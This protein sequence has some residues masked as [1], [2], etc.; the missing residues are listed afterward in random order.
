MCRLNGLAGG[1]SWLDDSNGFLCRLVPDGRGAPPADSGP[2]T[3]PNIQENLGGTAPGRTYQDLLTSAYEERLYDY[4]Y[5]SQ[6]AFVA[7]DGRKTTLGAPAVYASLALSTDGQW[8]VVTRVK[9][10][11]SY[12]VPAGLFP[13]D[14]EL[15]DRAGKVVRKLADAVTDAQRDPAVVARFAAMGLLMP[16]ETPAQFAAGLKAEAELWAETVRRGKI[17]IE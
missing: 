2:P 1:C 14:V 4:Y 3:G 10:P 7:L 16:K 5:T 17:T 13:R 9:R 6:P 12:V 8:L 15:W 11:Y